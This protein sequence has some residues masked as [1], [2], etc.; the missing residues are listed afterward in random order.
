[1][2]FVCL[3]VCLVNPKNNSVERSYQVRGFTNQY[4]KWTWKNFTCNNKESCWGG[5]RRFLEIQHL[6]HRWLFNF[7]NMIDANVNG[8]IVKAKKELDRLYIR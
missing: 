3:Y 4:D 2:F 8:K 1:M 7:Y 5:D 6:N